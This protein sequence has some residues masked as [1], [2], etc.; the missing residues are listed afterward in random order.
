MFTGLIEEIGQLK[1]IKRNGDSMRLSIAAQKIMD[2]LS[3]GDSVAVNGICLTVTDFAGGVFSA[4]V[5]QE[6]MNR[7]SLNGLTTG[8]KVNLERAMAAGGRFGGHFVSGHIDGVATL[9]EKKSQDNAVILKFTIGAELL[10]Y[11]V[12]KGSITID[13]ISLT[14]VRLGTAEFTVSVIP[15]TLA[16][17]TLGECRLG[18][19][20]NIEVD[21]LAKYIE[22]ILSGIGNAPTD[23]GNAITE[24]FLREQGF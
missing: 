3:V 7:T 20:V 19:L 22:R 9:I 5:M 11:L 18:D 13:G 4:D 15:H 23:G 14:I 10:K 6:T 8:S 16:E 24:E 1:S 2:D 17:T 12:P 21:M